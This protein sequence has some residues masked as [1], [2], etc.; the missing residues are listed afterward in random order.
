[1]ALIKCYECS[2]QISDLAPACPQCGAPKRSEPTA[3]YVVVGS[4]GPTDPTARNLDE[5]VQQ[6]DTLLDPETMRPY[7]GPAFQLFA[8]QPALLRSKGPV[9]VRMM[10]ALLDGQMHGPHETYH[11]GGRLRSKGEF[12]HGTFHPKWFDHGRD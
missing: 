7:S 9:K 6:G 2:K 1:M 11:K 3:V 12:I 4:Q 10:C 5:L 8:N